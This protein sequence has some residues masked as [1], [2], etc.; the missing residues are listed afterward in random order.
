[1]SAI[2]WVGVLVVAIGIAALLVLVT[3]PFNDL[4]AEDPAEDNVGEGK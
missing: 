2:G 3:K 1:M 4:P